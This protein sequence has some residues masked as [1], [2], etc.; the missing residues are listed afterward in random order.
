MHGGYKRVA[1]VL[2]KKITW[3]MSKRIAAIEIQASK[4]DPHGKTIISNCY[5][6]VLDVVRIDYDAGTVER[7]NFTVNPMQVEAHRGTARKLP[8][9]PFESIAWDV[10]DYLQGCDIMGFC[11]RR[12]DLPLL[13]EEFARAGID[14]FPSEN[15]SVIDVQSIFHQM[16]PRNF[17]A[18]V[19]FYLDQ[20][21]AAHQRNSADVELT[22]RIFD[23][24]I[25]RYGMG[26]D[27]DYLHE[28]SAFG[29]DLADFS[30]LLYW[31]DNGLKLFWNFGKNK[32][33]PVK[34]EDPFTIWFL[35][36]DFPAQSRRIVADYTNIQ[37][38]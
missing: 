8:R 22:R 25:E 36:N 4:I 35:R 11:V 30:S 23:R 13:A 19:R 34:A 3:I 10:M 7:A 32:D 6:S 21:Y 37:I 17:A 12:L 29:K 5:I 26:L 20:E 38:F 16:E 28:I 27:L 14:N 18:A 2:T 24:Q 31:Q 1:A 9:T 33:Q 15:I